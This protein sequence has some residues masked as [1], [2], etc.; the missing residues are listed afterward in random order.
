MKTLIEKDPRAAKEEFLSWW[1]DEDTVFARLRIW[2]CGH[3]QVLSGSEAGRTI[4]DLSDRAFWDDH[5]QRDL[6]LVLSKRWSD[7][8]RL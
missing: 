7:F 5:H 1:S 3:Q 6:L 2:A 8:P 4:H